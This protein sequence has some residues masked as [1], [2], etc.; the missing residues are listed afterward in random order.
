MPL[1]IQWKNKVSECIE[2]KIAKLQSSN[3]H[4]RKN[5]IFMQN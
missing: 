5:H 3:I 1:L 4:A 2:E